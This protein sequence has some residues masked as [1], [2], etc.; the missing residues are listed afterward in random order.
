MDA[1]HFF[2]IVD[3][4]QSGAIDFMEFMVETL[5]SKKI[6]L[7]IFIDPLSDDGGGVWRGILDKDIQS[8]R[9]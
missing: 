9:L 3:R 2:R 6:Y 7:E 4:N 8:L 5:K 1:D